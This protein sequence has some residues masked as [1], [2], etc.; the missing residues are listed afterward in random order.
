MTHIDHSKYKI[1]NEFLHWHNSLQKNISKQSARTLITDRY[2]HNQKCQQRSW[3]WHKEHW[4]GTIQQWK[5]CIL[6]FVMVWWVTMKA[7][8]LLFVTKKQTHTHPGTGSKPIGPVTLWKC[9]GRHC[10]YLS[11]RSQAS[12]SDWSPV[13]HNKL[14][15]R[16][17]ISFQLHE[18]KW[19]PMPGRIPSFWFG[20]QKQLL[21]DTAHVERCSAFWLILHLICADIFKTYITK[22]PNI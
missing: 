12:Q 8:G 13:S 4:R 3:K 21:C 19:D 17:T 14:F 11:C 2:S 5:C 15:A 18:N 20:P 6:I 10:F 9:W 7:F 1:Y 22:R 16:Q